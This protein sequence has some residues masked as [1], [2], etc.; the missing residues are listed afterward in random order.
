MKSIHSLLKYLLLLIAFSNLAQAFYDSGQGRWLSRDSIEER[1]GLNLYEFAGNDGIT[2]VDY[3]GRVG[4]DLN[5]MS[6]FMHWLFGGGESLKVSWSSFDPTG[7]A[8]DDLKQQWRLAN[9]S[10]ITEECDSMEW[11]TTK[12][13]KITSPNLDIV[14]F[15]PIGWISGWHG[16]I[17]GYLSGGSGNVDIWKTKKDS[18]CECLAIADVRM[19]AEDRSNFN[20]GDTF[21]DGLGLEWRDDWFIWARDNTP[22]GYDYDIYNW[23]DGDVEWKIEYN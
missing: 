3:L 23:E 16:K 19:R 10:K 6:G 22:V 2:H 5:N 7:A 21:I 1:G 13:I 17:S 12:T 20:V 15:S 18:K 8:R 4:V 11:D 9:I 14:Y